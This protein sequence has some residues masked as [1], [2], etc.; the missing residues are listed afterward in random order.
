MTVADVV[1]TDRYPTRLRSASSWIERRDPVV[2]PGVRKGPAGPGELAAHTTKGFH[3]QRLL[4]PEEARRYREELYLLAADS[5]LR[6]DGRLVLE[7]DSREVRSIFAVHR[8]SEAV[9]ALIRR[10]RILDHARQLLGSDVYVHQSR[11]N[12]MPGFTGSGFYWHSDFESWHAEDGMPAPRA[13]SLSISL[14]DNH[15]FNG[16]LMLV[17]GAHATFVPCVGE[18]P[19]DNYRSS[20]E[21]Q[22]IGVPAEEDITR[23][24]ERHGIEQFTGPAGTALWFDS[25]SM[26]ASGNNITPYPRSNL[27]VVFNSVDNALTEP[28]AAPGHRPEFVAARDFAPLSRT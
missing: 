16:G 4:G 22:R 28:Y 13:V 17:P 10:P 23:L 6:G 8:L 20:L 12:F 9:A 26:H 14:T 19:E 27:F 5:E 15:P 21:R 24:V 11:V 25:N 3:T 7:P 1:T 2:W 18:T